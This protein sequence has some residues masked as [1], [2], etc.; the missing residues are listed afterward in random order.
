VRYTPNDPTFNRA[1][2]LQIEGSEP[3]ERVVFFDTE[4]KIREVVYASE[5]DNGVLQ[6]VRKRLEDRGVLKAVVHVSATA[7]GSRS[8]HGPRYST[9]EYLPDGSYY[10]RAHRVVPST[11]VSKPE[12]IEAAV[13]ATQ[14]LFNTEQEE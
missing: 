3:D 4:N 1:V 5:F 9:V 12:I 13:D 7:L 6:A 8:G 11:W 2:D 14:Q 10:V